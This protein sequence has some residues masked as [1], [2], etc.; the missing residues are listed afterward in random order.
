LPTLRGGGKWEKRIAL[1][2]LAAKTAAEKLLPQ[3]SNLALSLFS[4]SN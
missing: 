1:T 4:F 2:P 3:K